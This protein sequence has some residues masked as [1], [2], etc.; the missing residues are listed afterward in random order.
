MV[1]GVPIFAIIYS[2][3]KEIVEGKLRSK[4]LPE[5]TEEYM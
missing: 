5:D 4:G 2:V 1:V 3:I